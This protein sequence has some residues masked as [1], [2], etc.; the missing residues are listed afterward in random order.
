MFVAAM[1]AAGFALDDPLRVV[2]AGLAEIPR[3]SRL[4]AA[5]R[6]VIGLCRKHRF[7]CEAF[8]KVFDEI[9]ARFGHYSP[10]HT[11]PN[12]ALVVA[13]LLLGGNDFEKVI[14]LAV[15]GGWDTDCNGATAG[16]IFGAMHGAGKIP[17][18][19]KAPLHDTLY[20]QIFDYHPRAISECARLSL[21]IAQKIMADSP[22]LPA[23]GRP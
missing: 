8:E 3:R 2:E 19:W 5:V 1:I 18:R 9:E 12:A 16:S 21:G 13:A 22:S 23:H 11:L 15:M 20:A 14:T 7:A 10:V 6:E 17:D 4:H